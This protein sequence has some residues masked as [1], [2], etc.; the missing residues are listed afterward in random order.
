MIRNHEY[1][2]SPKGPCYE[3]HYWQCKLLQ[4]DYCSLLLGMLQLEFHVISSNH[5]V[6]C[7]V[8]FQIIILSGY[9]VM[10]QYQ[11]L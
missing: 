10:T 1:I 3:V 5:D 7:F 8:V 9:F 6:V 11:F 4:N 2:K